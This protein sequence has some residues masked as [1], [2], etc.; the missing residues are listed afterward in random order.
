MTSES[1]TAEADTSAADDTSEVEDTAA[2]EGKPVVEDTSVV[3]DVTITAAVTLSLENTSVAEKPKS[4]P[5]SLEAGNKAKAGEDCE[6]DVDCCNAAAV[7]VVLKT[8]VTW[9]GGDKD[10]N[11]EDAKLPSEVRS[12]LSTTEGAPSL[13]VV[14]VS[15][16]T[17]ELEV[18]FSLVV[19]V[20]ELYK[21]TGLCSVETAPSEDEGGGA[22]V[23]AAEGKDC[24]LAP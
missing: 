3:V 21:T 23:G 9:V 4:S 10:A 18:R 22:S 16:R 13:T 7:S 24:V 19:G 17:V 14:R 2:E 12:E 20:N 5:D 6:Y 1:K 15:E 11:A 8:A